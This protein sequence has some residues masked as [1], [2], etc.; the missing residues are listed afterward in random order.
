MFHNLCCC[1]FLTVLACLSHLKNFFQ[2]GKLGEINSSSGN[3]FLH[4][5]SRVVADYNNNTTTMTS[6]ACFH[7]HVDHSLGRGQDSCMWNNTKK[8]PLSSHVFETLFPSSFTYL[9]GPG[10][11]KNHLW[12][13]MFFFIGEHF[14]STLR[15]GLLCFHACLTNAKDWKQQIRM[16]AW[17]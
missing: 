9:K 14:R 15:T 10:K 11:D 5:Q 4:V 12:E 7:P 2:P 6:K 1:E 17:G 13:A 3:G 8:V 16:W